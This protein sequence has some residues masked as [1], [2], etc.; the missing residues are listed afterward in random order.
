MYLNVYKSCSAF[1]SHF[2]GAKTQ[3]KAQLFFSLLQDYHNESLRGFTEQEICVK[4][5]QLM[6]HM[7]CV[8]SVWSGK[9]T[10]RDSE[11]NIGNAISS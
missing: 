5:C 9:Y 8:T 4:F 1:P 10:A 11:V 6:Q 7:L 2:K 3:E